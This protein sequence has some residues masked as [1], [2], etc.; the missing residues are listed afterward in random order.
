MV[1]NQFYLFKDR[2]FLPIFLVQFLGCLNDGILKNALIILVTFKLANELTIEPYI[3]V[4]L[5]NTI[6]IAPL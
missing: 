6:F 2:R 4:M 5:A 3:L 1:S